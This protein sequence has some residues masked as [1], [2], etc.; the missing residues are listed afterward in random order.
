[1]KRQLL[2]LTIVFMFFT[3]FLCADEQDNTLFIQ[4]KWVFTGH[5]ILENMVI[6]IQGD[7]IVSL[8]PLDETEIPLNACF[9]DA[10]NQ[11][12]LPGFIDG[13]VHMTGVSYQYLKNIYRMGWGRLVEEYMSFMAENRKNYLEHGVTTI[14]DMGGSIDTLQS[15]VKRADRGKILCPDICMAGPIFT[16]PEGHPAGTI[17]KGMH[18]LI[19]QATIQAGPSF[20]AVKSVNKLVEKNTDFIKI[21]YDGGENH[22][23]NRLDKDI[24]KEIIKAAHKKGKPVFVH[25]W[26]YLSDAEDMVYAGADGLEHCFLPENSDELLRYM[27]E[28]NVFLTPTLSVFDFFNTGHLPAMQKTVKQAYDAGVLLAVGTDFPASGSFYAGEDVFKEMRLLEQAGIPR[29]DVLKAA[30][31]H[32]AAKI[33]KEDTGRIAPGCRAHLVFFN[34]N[35]LEGDLVPERIQKVMIYGEVIVDNGEIAETAKPKFKKN[36]MSFPSPYG[37]YTPETN[38]VIGLNFNHFNIFNTGTAFISNFMYSLNNWFSCQFMFFPPSPIPYTN[39]QLN[40]AYDTF[41]DTFYGIVPGDD[42]AVQYGKHRFFSSLLTQTKLFRRLFLHTS[43]LFD[44]HWFPRDND[45][46]LLDYP[47]FESA[48]TTNIG[49]EFG[50]DSR[51]NSMNPWEGIYLGLGCEFSHPYLLGSSAFIKLSLDT[52]F[53]IHLPFDHVLALHVLSENAFGDIPFYS[54]P[55]FGGQQIGRG[56]DNDRFLGAY[57]LFGQVEY[58]FPVWSVIEGALFCDFGQVQS[59]YADFTPDQILYSG[60]GGLRLNFSDNTIL[61]YDIGFA[62]DSWSIVFRYGHSF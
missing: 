32:N 4:A 30:T 14:V 46:I 60:G 52:R 34:G 23:W 44:Y 45:E 55:E 13:H 50:Y 62:P 12:V 2:C 8:S 58:R 28:N 61:C 56:Y 7:R 43:V 6:G 26:Y 38:I 5:D 25:V 29:I 59:G 27:A 21:V 49:C 37:Y 3:H 19:K 35:C 24:A 40:I 48:F 18:Q 10:G 51:D 11:T 57:G 17:Y 9:I 1:M 42:I 39:L 15:I 36:G 54:M 41:H 16:A 53:Y 31:I 33:R 22:D 47:G 20:D